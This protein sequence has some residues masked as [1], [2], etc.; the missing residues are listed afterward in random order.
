MRNIKVFSRC[1]GH[2]TYQVFIKNEPH[3]WDFVRVVS[4]NSFRRDPE[5]PQYVRNWIIISPDKTNTDDHFID[6]FTKSELQAMTFSYLLETCRRKPSRRIVSYDVK[7]PPSSK[8]PKT[9]GASTDFAVKIRT[10]NTEL[11]QVV[12]QSRLNIKDQISRLVRQ[13]TEL[14]H[15]VSVEEIMRAGEH[16]SAIGQDILQQIKFLDFSQPY[17]LG[18]PYKQAYESVNAIYAHYYEWFVTDF[19]LTE[20]NGC[21]PEILVDLP[22]HFVK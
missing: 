11:K 17:N 3:D 22:I 20:P 14:I 5:K 9:I 12:E 4:F 19:G 16:D 10:N 15:S 8:L 1:I 6:E 21:P 13:Y 2:E 7:A 18:V